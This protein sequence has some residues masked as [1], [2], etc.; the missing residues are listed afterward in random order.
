MTEEFFNVRYHEIWQDKSVPVWIL[1]NYAQ[2]AAA[3]DA[4]TFS[5][6]WEDF[7]Q[8]VAWVLTKI[9]FRLTGKISSVQKIKV[10]TWHV[11]SDK[12]YSRRDFI[13][14]DEY[15]A[16]VA[17]A[18]SKWLILD[19][20]K[21]RIIRTPQFLLEKKDCALKFA[22]QEI[23]RPAPA[24]F[25]AEPVMQTVITSRLEDLDLNGHVNNV[26]F[27]SWAL[28]G[29]PPLIWETK[30]LEYISTDFKSEL[31]AGEII[32]VKTYDNLDGSFWHELVK[33]SDSKVA[34]VAFSKWI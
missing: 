31:K 14:Y 26:H 1:Q 22:M 8:G 19:L 15:G 6:G 30:T 13:I 33:Q 5:L 24:K 23:E 2:Q 12:I 16:E 25:S 10:K 21:H 27:T 32:T 17:K 9:S 28:E 18:V 20:A 29:V 34:A 11:S 3:I 7:P 4:K